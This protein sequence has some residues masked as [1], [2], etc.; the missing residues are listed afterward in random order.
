MSA[1]IENVGDPAS[2]F[3][4]GVPIR[5]YQRI[6]QAL[7]LEIE[8][9]LYSVGS[10]LPSEREL[11]SKFNISRPTLREALTVLE[12]Q[13]LVEIRG[14][15]G[16][17]VLKIPESFTNCGTAVSELE[18]IEARLHFAGEAAALAA[19]HISANEIAT[20]KNLIIQMTD[21]AFDKERF[22][23]VSCK[24][25]I[26]IAHATRNPVVASTIIS[27]WRLRSA[28]RILPDGKGQSLQI[29]QHIKEYLAIVV[30]LENS[31][32]PGSRAAMRAHLS[33]VM[34][35]MLLTAELEEVE[36]AKHAAA[37]TRERYAKTRACQGF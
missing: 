37:L 7:T 4:S 19:A 36:K 22:E 21:G 33:A 14:G 24:F 29:Q 25:Y 35:R 32:V 27:L 26:V 2:N 34:D 6:A 1:G 3:E 11:S 15:S 10:R 12:S 23:N 8:T 28:E 31:D 18:I 5:A 16:T 30:A 9:G 20:L 17:T 13:G